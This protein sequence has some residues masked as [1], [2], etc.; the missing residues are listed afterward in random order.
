M[1]SWEPQPYATLNLNSYLLDPGF[2]FERG[3]RYLLGAPAFDRENGF[4]Y[5]F[6]R[7]TDG[8]DELS[9]VHVLSVG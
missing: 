2:D 8:P 5:I 7:M 3:K 9:V 6:E 4:L 1:N